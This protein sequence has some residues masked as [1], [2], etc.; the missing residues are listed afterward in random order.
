ML[1]TWSRKPQEVQPSGCSY[2][3]Y[4]SVFL[5]TGGECAVHSIY[6]VQ[7]RGR[8]SPLPCQLDLSFLVSALPLV[9]FP[10]QQKHGRKESLPYAGSKLALKAQFV[11]LLRLCM[12]PCPG[13][14]FTLAEFQGRNM[15][16]P[17]AFTIVTSAAATQ[18]A[19]VSQKDARRQSSTVR[20]R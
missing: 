12:H 11:F 13:K 15:R 19:V 7:W 14:L 10:L 2:C 17:I 20:R 3:F 6:S 5:S 8:L 18:A 4:S 1:V 9:P 16:D